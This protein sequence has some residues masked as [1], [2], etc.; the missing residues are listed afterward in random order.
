MSGFKFKAFLLSIFLGLFILSLKS[1]D[2][3]N[4]KVD[5]L[6]DAQITQMIKKAEASGMTQ[7]QLEAAALAK[8]MP[9]A[10]VQKLKERIQKLQNAG[11]KTS[12]IDIQRE[13]SEEFLDETTVPTTK[14][15]TGL[16]QLFPT[17]KKLDEQMKKYFGFD[18]FTSKNLTFE[19]SLN[20]STPVNYQLGPGDEII[21]DIWGASQQNYKLKISP[22]GSIF[23]DNVGPVSVSGLTIDKAQVKIIN[24]LSNIYAGLRGTNPN[25]FAQVSIGNIRSI[26]VTLL[27]EVNM[28]GSYT[29]TSLATV[30]NALYVSGG[31]SK[32]GSLR[33]IEV[34]R[35]NKLMVT[36]DVYDFLIY[37]D[38]SKNIRLQDQD[39][40]KVNPYQ[41]RIELVGEFKRPLI[42]EVKEGETL[43]KVIRFSGGFTDKAYTHRLR[44]Q[45]KTSRE[46][47]MADVIKENFLSFK[48]IDGDRIF[49]DAILDR[50]ENRVQIDGAVFRPGEY[51]LT[52]GLTLKQLIEKA[53]G[54]RGDA[55]LNRAL[56]YRVMPDF[57]IES[58][59]VDLKLLSQGNQEDIQLVKDDIVKVFS[60]FDLQEEY[61]VQI[62]GEVLRPGRFPFV[63]K[64][65]LQ[66]II[67]E[68]GG[69]RE[70]ASLSRIEI[71]RRVKNSDLNDES[72]KIAEVFHFEVSKDLKISDSAS[73]FILEPFDRIFI[74]R[75]PGYEVQTAALIRGEVFYPG[76]YSIKTKDERISDLVSR[77]GGFTKEAYPKGARLIRMINENQRVRKKILAA[78]E[79][80][81][82]GD[83]IKLL[84]DNET[85]Q[86]IG[87]DLERIM[88]KPGSKYDLLLQDGDVLEI[89]KELQTVRLSGAVLYPITVRYDENYDV[90]DYISMAGG[91][92]EDALRRKTFVIYPNGSADKT[93]SFLGIKA[94]P[95]IEPGAE[96]IVPKKVERK[97]KMSV[98]ETMALVTIASSLTG[99]VIAIINLN[100]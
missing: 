16:N 75:S 1:Q 83:S 49:A 64:M 39:V 70:S 97:D 37:G 50:Y 9:A 99:I 19:P 24:R 17:D 10:E 4:I 57:T 88:Q 47:A 11:S 67:A 22:E 82:Q 46:R 74:R 31:P 92:S 45:R 36:L 68:A 40:I 13:R 32:N 6:S 33:S 52:E 87:I 14:D 94:Y 48:L 65:S 54:L 80:E 96:I 5:E 7:Q 100:N 34:F 59:S 56:I 81:T 3:Q 41:T 89:P 76:A 77:S 21:I 23:I 42:Y 8:G 86:F 91:F 30:F 28:P 71:A 25:T 69:F 26:K 20:I 79:N 98:Q 58:L 51:E 55:F 53:E 90:R 93:N 29:L 35:E 38:Q 60:I 61:N 43:D 18:L 84:I 72:A 2:I 12:T 78:I 85:E 66:N 44:I 15:Q 73:K 27:G 95:N 63:Y 62:D